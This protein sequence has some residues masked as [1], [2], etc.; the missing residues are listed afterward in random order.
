M[1][2]MPAISLA[3]DDFLDV[4]EAFF[5]QLLLQ[6]KSEREAKLQVT[7]HIAADH[8]LY[9]HAFKVTKKAGATQESLSFD[10][11]SGE[12]TYDP[13]QEKDLEIYTNDILQT[14]PLTNWS[15]AFSIELIAQGCSKKG[16]C[17]S[18]Y[19]YQFGISN[20]KVSPLNDKANEKLKEK[21]NLSLAP[22]SE[23][24]HNMLLLVIS[25]F[26][27]GLI[28]NLMPCVFPVLSLKALSF[29][30]Q[31]SSA[32]EQ[33][34]HGWI[35]TLGV[36]S[37]FLAAAAIILIA[38]HLGEGIGWGF[39]LQQPVFVIFMV[40]LFF[41]M[42]LNLLGFIELGGAYAGL[43]QELTSG[44]KRSASF[45]TGVLAVLVASPCTA[46]FMASALGVALTQSSIYTL[47]IFISLGLGMASPFLL[48]SYVPNAVEYLPKPGNWMT[49]FKQ[50]LSFPLFITAIWLLW[51]LSHQTASDTIALVLLGLVCITFSVWMMK[52]A[53]AY[54]YKKTGKLIAQ[55]MAILSLVPAIAFAIT[56]QSSINLNE[57]QIST[58]YSSNTLN[59]LRKNNKAVFI[60]V[61]AEWCITCKVNEK[62]ALTDKVKATLLE[63]GIVT[64]VAD[65]TNKNI[66]V[67]KLLKQH[68]RS[69]IPLYIMYPA[70]DTK[71]RILPQVLSENI[72]LDAIQEATKG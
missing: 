37:S 7:W 3:D 11:P 13:F 32:R 2:T 5:P 66:E 54:Q 45:F 21:N 14:I 23:K 9:R 46:P 10:M 18:P 40:Y 41:V 52:N 1:F 15:E 28:L 27:G 43:G 42:G 4:T 17:Y 39:Q 70:G 44:N 64:L 60:D 35:Y 24:T 34:V 53:K 62:V 8:Y 48:L 63:R 61:T 57:Q 36:T 72:M 71:P 25:A 19:S 65:W 50:V 33:H 38:R 47:A 68:S 55:S 31:Y 51:V 56:A 12:L 30:S 6:H 26:I 29:T 59:E 16:L 22:T 20:G 69:G 49:I 67:E 58:P